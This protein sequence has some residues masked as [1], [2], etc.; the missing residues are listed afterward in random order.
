MAVQRNFSFFLCKGESYNIILFFQ[1]PEKVEWVKQMPQALTGISLSV[2][3][4][5]I[6]VLFPRIKV[7]YNLFLF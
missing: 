7:K 6:V 1:I 3:V 5:S 2:H 4:E